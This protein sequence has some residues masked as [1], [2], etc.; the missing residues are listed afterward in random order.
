[1]AE[2]NPICRFRLGAAPASGDEV[3]RLFFCY[4]PREA[5]HH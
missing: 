2:V 4:V 5:E 3:I 1:M